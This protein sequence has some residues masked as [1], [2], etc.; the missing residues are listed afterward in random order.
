VRCSIAVES[1]DPAERRF[2]ALLYRNYRLYWL[3]QLTGNVGS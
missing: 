1:R 3:A 2:A